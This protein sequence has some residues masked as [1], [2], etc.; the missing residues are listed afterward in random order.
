MNVDRAAEV[1]LTVDRATLGQMPTVPGSAP[2]EA[3]WIVAELHATAAKVNQS[4]ENYRFDDAANTIYQF[5]WGTF[6]DWYLEIVKLRLDFSET[7]DKARTK[8]ALTTLVQVFE[9]A[10]RLLS[11]FMPFITEELWN[12]VYD[13]NPPMKSI[14]LMGYPSATLTDPDEATINAMGAVQALIETIRGLRKDVGVGEKTPVPVELKIQ[15]DLI[16]ESIESNLDIIERL[17][18]ASEVRFVRTF[19]S[20]LTV[21]STPLFDVAVVYEATIDVPTE[22]ERLTK[23]IAKYEKGLAAA[24]RQLG[25]EGFLAKAPAQIVEGLKKQ[26]AET[27]LLLEKARAA[28]AALPKS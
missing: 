7:A 4:L 17:A 8:A 23:D 11:P 6:C 13:G 19:S 26:E 25:N 22:R 14:A 28:L 15:L 20:G 5:F 1:G 12:A 24:E 16:A 2:L 3:R 27:R 9:C 18:R 10:V 21:A